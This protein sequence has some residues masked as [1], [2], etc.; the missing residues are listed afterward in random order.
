MP[1]AQGIDDKQNLQLSMQM[2]GSYEV[3]QTHIPKDGAAWQRVD[4]T[5][6]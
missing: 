2:F 6:G 1:K 3:K 5:S 4:K